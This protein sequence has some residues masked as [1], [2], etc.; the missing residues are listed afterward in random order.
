[1]SRQGGNEARKISSPCTPLSAKDFSHATERHHAQDLKSDGTPAKLADSEGLYL[2]L[3][4]SGGKLWRM[5]YRYAGKRKTLSFGAYPAVSLKDARRKRDKAKELLANDIDPGAQKKAAKEEAEAAAREQALTFAV[6]AQEWFATKQDSYA[7]A[8][9]KKKQWLISLL[10]E[11]IGEKP[12][13]KLVPTDILGAIRPVEAAGHSVTAH[14]LAETAGQICRFARTCGYIVFNPA[15]GLKEVLKPIQTRHYATMTDP[16]AVGHLLRC[17]DEYQG[18]AVV[19]YALKI[20]PY[21][22]LRSAELRGGRWS[23]IDLDKALWIVPAARRENAKDGGGMKMRIAHAVPLPTQAVKLFR[24]LHLLT[25]TGELCFPGRHSA[26][27]CISDMALL[28]GIRRMGFS[29]EEMTIHGFRAMFSTILNEKKLEW[30]FDGDIIEAQ[31]AHKEQNAVRDAYN[32]AS[33]L[34]KRRELLQRW[35]DYLDELRSQDTSNSLE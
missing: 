17:I 6:V 20:L 26:S 13:S 24:E 10:N 3:S 8:N 7:A 31:L 1:M 33:Y 4:A 19:G 2:Y 30:G 16:A 32:H 23:E 5:D 28:N 14:K 27:Q 18:G 35:A 29:K 11:R 12:I 34:D 21:L 25:G 15:D 9:I 22:A